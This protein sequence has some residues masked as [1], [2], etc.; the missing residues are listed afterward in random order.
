M[1]PFSSDIPKDMLIN[2][3]TGEAASEQMTDFL[4]NIEKI[5]EEKKKD[6]IDSCSQD[7]TNFEKYK[8]KNTKIVNFASQVKKITKRIAGKVQ[9]VKLQSDVFGRL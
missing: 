3:S 4:L 2:I 6:L 5:G 9:E 1:N 8:I 7:S